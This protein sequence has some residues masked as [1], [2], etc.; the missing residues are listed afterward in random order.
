M[1]T[2]F[3][4]DIAAKV[5]TAAYRPARHPN[6]KSA[7]LESRHQEP[8]YV[9]KQPDTRRYL[10]LSESDYAL[11]WLMDGQHTIKDLLFYHFKRYHSLP[12][13]RLNTLV[14]DLRDGRFLQ[15]TPT[16]LYDQIEKALAEREPESQGRRLLN[17]FLHTEMSWT[18][19]EPHFTAVYRAFSWLFLPV[20]QILLWAFV[21]VGAGLFTWLFWQ[22][23]YPLTGQNGRGV[24]GLLAANLL[25]IGIHEMAHGLAVKHT[26]REMDRAGFLIYWGFPAFFVDTRDIWMS[27]Q[28]ARIMVSWAGPFSGLVVGA[29][30]GWVLTAVSPTLGTPAYTLA[31]FLYQ[32]GFLAFFS[33]FIN[34][35]PLLELDGYFML[36]DWLEI[37]NLRA[38]AFA[39]LRQMGWAQWRQLLHHPRQVW[40]NWD[41]EERIFLFFGLLAFGYSAYALL[42]ALY[43][44]QTRIVPGLSALWHMEAWW[45]P[46]LVLFLTAVFILPALYFL[47]Q[48]GW[49]RIQAGLEWLSRHD[50]LVRPDVL[51]LLLGSTLFGGLTLL[52][53]FITRLSNIALWLTLIMWLLHLFAVVAL[54]VVAWQLRGSRF[55]WSLWS[56]VGVTA[57]LTLAWLSQSPTW[58]LAWLTAASLLFLAAGLVAW[59]TVQPAFLETADK[60]L[61][62]VFFLLAVGYA[63]VGLIVGNDRVWM[64]WLLLAGIFGGLTAFSPLLVNFYHSRFSLPWMLLVLGALAVP[65]LRDVPLFH[66]PVIV[67]WLYAALLYLLLGTMAEFQRQAI[68]Q[69]DIAAFEER[70]RLVY[71]FNHFMSAFFAIY[72][73]VFGGRRLAIIQ[74]QMQALGAVDPDET[75]LQIAERCETALL[76]AVDRLDDLAG[77]PFTLAAGQAAYDSL[78]WLEAETLGR[79]VLAETDWGR[80]FVGG[81]GQL[82]SRREEL[83]RQAD[84]FAGFDADAVTQTLAVSDE[85]KV[86][87]GAVIARVGEDATR[88]YLVESG[89]VGVF[90]DE[91][92]VAVLEPG[93]YFGMMALLDE[94][95]YLATYQALTAVTLLSISRSRFD[96]LLRAD[97]TLASQVTS[98][99]AERRILKQMPLFASLSPQQLTAVANR[100]KTREVQ[101]GEV[102]VQQGQPR[103]DLF[104]VAEGLVDVRVTDNGR[105]ETVGELGPGEHFGEYALF[106]DTPY[107]ATYVARTNGRLLLLDE[108]TFDELVA[109]Y[110]YMSHYVEQVGTGRLIA[111]RR[112]MGVTAVIS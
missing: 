16:H 106:A 8:Y 100:M 14:N 5:D 6:V 19:F 9:I 99:M 67:L 80:Q 77:T 76:L 45:G 98:G 46:A 84:I 34:L 81:I 11:W 105:I 95:A 13:G 39:F 82:Y 75:I 20:T 83:I 109:H 24:L 60:V 87:K 63:Y 102:I 72:E 50:L 89:R 10:R 90:H 68:E 49:D 40:A 47:L 66:I 79:N 91:E 85:V 36:M 37:P 23:A 33:V 58:R 12:F 88:F 71:A 21:L 54:G 44:W 26:G 3:W 18:G 15:E 48:Y 101:A 41:R 56:L 35:N 42:F 51:A 61:M 78:P 96:P 57:V 38:R 111:T 69:A 94:G 62:A 74:A 17:A 27:P 112:K 107:Q 2:K 59:F 52:G 4:E 110:A 29:V 86:R 108:P 22:K 55:Q 7:R 103:S 70:D 53:L 73:R 28:K 25:V 43:F 97:T 32:A 104:V 31:A 92:Q 93:G 30:A 65:W 64:D 1:A